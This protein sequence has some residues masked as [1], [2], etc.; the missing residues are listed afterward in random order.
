MT[1]PEAIKNNLVEQINGHRLLLELLQRERG[2]LANLTASVVE[3]LS[4]EK[5][6]IVLR[7]R[8]LEEE[9]IRLVKK[10]SE[11]RKLK[12]DINLLKLHELTGEDAFRHLRLQLISLLQSIKELN[13][14]NRILI[15]RSLSFIKSS[16]N[17]L[18][19]S[20]I[21]IKS[22]NHPG[23]VLSRQA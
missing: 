7:L 13:E 14:F 10:F 2:A 22:R 19:A 4:K 9:R 15:E 23:A 1:T 12:G 11:E 16:V 5:D 6:I 18:A 8:M 21:T 17:F 3:D 20:G